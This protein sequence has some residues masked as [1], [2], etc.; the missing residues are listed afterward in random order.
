MILLC[1]VLVTMH[2]LLILIKKIQLQQLKYILAITS[3]F[4]TS[5]LVNV[6]IKLQ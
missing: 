3:V 2:T 6:M 1:T 4:K 5:L